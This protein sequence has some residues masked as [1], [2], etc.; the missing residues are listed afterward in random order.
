MALVTLD[1]ARRH[2]QLTETDMADADRSAD[3]A[4]KAEQASEIVVDYIE[5]PEHGWAD[6]DAPFVVKAAVLLVLTALF[7]QRDE[8]ITDPVRSLLRRYRDP[9]LA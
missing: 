8:A 3:V 5:R 6:A 2:L 4:S 9:A 7:E 1:E